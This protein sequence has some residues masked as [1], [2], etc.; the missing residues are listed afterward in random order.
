MVLKDLDEPAEIKICLVKRWKTTMT[1]KQN[2]ALDQIRKAKLLFASGQI[3]E[4]I[5]QFTLAEKEGYELLDIWLSRGAALLAL[6][7]YKAAETD[8]SNVLQVQQDNERAYYYRGIARAAQGRHQKAISDL[9]ACLSRNNNR[10]I[11]HLIRGLSYAELGNRSEAILD[12]N[13]AG[14]FSDAELDSFAKLFGTIG[15]PFRNARAM[16]AEENAPWNNLLDRSS[17][18]KLMK[19]LQ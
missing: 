9:T 14:A 5:K 7:H 17:A 15:H 6:G 1:S 11:A 19:L 16:M 12:I 4:S 8:F 13:S 3:R 18:D 2:P 10:G